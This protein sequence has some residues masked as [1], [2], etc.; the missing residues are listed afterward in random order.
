MSR[1]R[2]KLAVADDTSLRNVT[3]YLVLVM[4]VGTT[5]VISSVTVGIDVPTRIL[6][7]LST[8]VVPGENP[9]PEIVIM[10]P[11]TTCLGEMESICTDGSGPP[12]GA[13]G[14]TAHVTR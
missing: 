2:K 12:C 11:S 13:P 10:S 3:T 4:L 8:I 5:K 9:D 6:P 7:G 14:I 1:I